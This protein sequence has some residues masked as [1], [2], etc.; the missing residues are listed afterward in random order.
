MK[1]LGVVEM[2]VIEKK[3]RGRPCKVTV[4]AVVD[5]TSANV[6]EDASKQKKSKAQ[7]KEGDDDVAPEQDMWWEDHPRYAELITEADDGDDT[8][9]IEIAD[10]VKIHRNMISVIITR[11][12]GIRL[13]GLVIGESYGAYYKSGSGD[14][15]YFVDTL[16]NCLSSMP[17][18]KS[19][20]RAANYSNAMKKRKVKQ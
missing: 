11:S 6:N 18:G 13:E 7:P 2:P 8:A 5:G 9:L 17:K 3:K 20:R 10:A 1:K 12:S 19:K 4:P 15:D 14:Y 16:A